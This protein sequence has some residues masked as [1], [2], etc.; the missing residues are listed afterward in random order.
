[1]SEVII[2]PTINVPTM[3]ISDDA[4]IGLISG[5]LVRRGG[6]IYNKGGG[7]FEHL[8][9]I[10]QPTAEK[11]KKVLSNTEVNN[12]S[13]NGGKVNKILKYT[14]E[15]KGK[16][17]LILGGVIVGVSIGYSIRKIAQSKKVNNE[18][19][20]SNNS[21]NVAL[22]KY[23]N[24][25]QKGALTFETISSLSAELKKINIESENG[26]YLVNVKQFKKLV[27]YILKYTEDL[28]SVNNYLINDVDKIKNPENNLF[29]L[30]KYLEIQKDIFKRRA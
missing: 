8:K 2:M 24:E 25:A 13:S 21:F 12:I 18:G 1:M 30:S 6:V 7:I 9:D 10:T 29:E 28:A 11:V 22:D 23:L 17:G 14:S 19:Q 26:V 5:E 16:T 4:V 3:E 15:N 27:G 20:V